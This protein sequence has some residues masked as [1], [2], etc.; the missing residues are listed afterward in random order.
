VETVQPRGL[1][2]EQKRLLYQLFLTMFVAKAVALLLDKPNL[3]FPMMVTSW[4]VSIFTSKIVGYF[5]ITR[6]V[7]ALGI[8][9]YLLAR[10]VFPG[11]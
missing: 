4:A 3:L 11:L 10:F 7:L 8:L 5:A 1:L 9:Q 6:G 2:P